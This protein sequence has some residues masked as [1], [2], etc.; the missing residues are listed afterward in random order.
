M[1]LHDLLDRFGL[2]EH[3]EVEQADAMR[4]RCIHCGDTVMVEEADLHLA[5]CQR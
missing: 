1:T 3:F 2:R 4:L 5:E